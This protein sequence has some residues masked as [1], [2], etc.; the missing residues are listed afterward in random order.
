MSPSGNLTHLQLRGFSPDSLPKLPQLTAFCRRV[1]PAAHDMAIRKTALA[2]LLPFPELPNVHD[3]FIG[4]AIAALNG[5]EVMPEPLT[6]FRQHGKNASGSGKKLSWAGQLQAAK[7]S[8]A[9]NTFLWNSQLYSA[10]IERLAD[11]LDE[12]AKRLLTERQIHSANRAKM[13]DCGMFKRLCLIA[14]ELFTGRY[15]RFARGLKSIVQ[16]LFLR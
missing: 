7:K 4:T 10:V 8:I 13:G 12:N 14:G 15:F 5:W 2:F 1:P 16:D 3:S 11:R 9:S 6:L